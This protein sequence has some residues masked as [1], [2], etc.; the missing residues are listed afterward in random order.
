M[1]KLSDLFARKGL[2][3]PDKLSGRPGDNN[4]NGGS[5]I[6]VE[7][8]SDVGAR[9]GEEN[10][11]LRNLLSDTGRKISELDDLKQA[12]DKLVAPFNST[13]RAL[14][15]EKSQTLSLSGM[16]AES[17]TAYETLR[18]EFYQIERR[19]TALEAEVEKLREDLELARE[20]SR[21]L[22]STRL[23][24][25]DEIN[26]LR[27]HAAELDRQ[28][29]HET[30][31]RRSVSEARRTLQEQLDTAEKRIVQLEG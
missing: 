25:T 27:A 16:L 13:L 8:L 2:A 20:T 7:H 22:E 4:G 24:L 29:A 10:E 5:P 3:G 11:V 30:A 31:Q 14:E 6:S 9:M 1:A 28:L 19:A 17:R 12:F 18:T 26:A 21:G 23:E 15:Q